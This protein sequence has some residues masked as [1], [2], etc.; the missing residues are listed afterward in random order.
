MRLRAVAQ[1]LRQRRGARL[2][3]RAIWI[4]LAVWSMGLLITLLGFTLP[5]LVFLGTSLGAL[6]VGIAY[7]WF[8][9]P[10]LRQ[11]A[12]GMDSF[13]A[14]QEQLA[15]AL[16]VARRYPRNEIEQRL[17]HNADTMLSNY[18]RYLAQQPIV[19]WREVETLVAVTL[20]A[21][22]L[23]IANGRALPQAEELVA[24]PTLPPVSPTDTPQSQ[25]DDQPVEDQSQPQLGLDA[26]EAAAA[27]A[28][29]LRDNG[30]T[31]AAAEA[32][33]R[34]DLQGA[35]DRL[36][37]LADQVDQLSEQARS[38]IA[39]GL[40]KAADQ[41][42]EAQPDLADHL[43]QLAEGLEW[44]EQAAEEALED[45]ARTIEQLGQ[46]GLPIAEAGETAGEAQDSAKNGQDQ[47]GGLGEQAMP[48]QGTMSGGLGAGNQLG[49]EAR[50][51]QDSSVQAQGEVVPLPHTDEQSD[52]TTSATG[53]RGPT[54]QLDVSGSGGPRSS[55][56][57]N[58]D[59]AL[60]GAADPLMIPPEY[61][62]VVEEYFTP[63]P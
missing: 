52:Q 60:P 21:L 53:P 15:T 3:L 57:N 8:S 16:E 41:L 23:T 27:I 28:D 37:E 30:A 26:Q 39:G 40:R 34:G 36:R 46:P 1:L 2:S 56:T 18:Q 43:E 4:A 20:L 22:G 45:L 25:A 44:D 31:R 55:A 11:L 19:P 59:Q 24:L 61:R 47:T 63:A 51:T 58:S 35:A 62:D 33:D 48:G 10:S 38:D 6:V 49:G 5:P 7:A 9:H 17:L 29:A 50:S 14:L 42:R 12:H 32:L 13:Y 54:I